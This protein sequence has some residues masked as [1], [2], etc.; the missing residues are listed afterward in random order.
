MNTT[1]IIYASKHGT[2]EKTANLIAEKIGKEPV[3]LINLNENPVITIQSF[4]K[5]ILGTAIYAGKPMSS[6]FR[7]C[8]EYSDILSTKQLGLFVCGMIP[9]S[10]T[11]QKELSTAYPS[12]MYEQSVARA[13][14]GGQFIF[15]QM[16]IL[17]R[18]IVKRIAK[19][20]E[21]IS[22]IKENK[23]DLFVKQMNG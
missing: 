7:F 15:A 19:A 11:Q 13:F 4:D 17:E 14:L 2:T 18:F 16:N 22:D 20:K 1:A 9:D 8:K 6:M 5:I 3:T 23:I 21:D 10:E 12:S